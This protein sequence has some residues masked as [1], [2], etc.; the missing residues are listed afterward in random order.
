MAGLFR[1][2]CSLLLLGWSLFSLVARANMW[3]TGYYPG[4]EQGAM[5]AS[6]ID[7]TALSHVIHFSL[8]PK[9][10][11]TLNSSDNSITTAN[12]ADIISHAHASGAKVLI[13]VGGASTETLFQGATSNHLSAFINNLTNFMASR[14]YDGIDVDWEPLPASDTRQFTNLVNG[15]RSALNGFPQHKLLTAAAGAYPSFGDP[16]AAQYQMYASLQNQFDQINIMTYDLS[17]PYPGWVTWFNSPIFD[18]GYRFPSTGGL[19]PSINGAVNNF[20]SGG[21]APGKLGI[22]I[23]FY[24]YVWTGGSGTTTGGVTQP[25]Q[26]WTT[27]PN[28]ATPSYTSI[29]AGS[30]QSNLYRWDTAAQ[31][32]YLTISNA[33]PAN[34]MFISYEDPRACQAKVS[35]ARNH[36]LGGIM[37]WELAQDHQGGQPDP[38]LQAVKQAL[39]SPGMVGIQITNRKVMLTFTGVALG[40]YR[41]QW[42][43][44]LTNSV[45]NTLAVTNVS[46]DNQ[47][48]QVIDPNPPGQS[49]KFY[50]VQSPQ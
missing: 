42:I 36:G 4:W 46:S 20:L 9:S 38:L 28:V 43:D 18:G 49:Q 33:T 25:R 21:V 22:G 47:L 10:D 29:V 41:I 2:R 19:V 39:A 17:G 11:G 40:S 23:P 44:T 37:I 30:Y 15:L 14:G 32:A 24:G 34:D 27:A 13:C 1:N 31:T 48:L 8:G 16:P 45:W 5:P 50:R 12:S 7:F 35:Y 26:T 6:N 3:S